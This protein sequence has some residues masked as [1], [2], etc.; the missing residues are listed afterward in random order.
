[1]EKKGIIPW[2]VINT[3]TE[4]YKVDIKDVDRLI[5]MIKQKAGLK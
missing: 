4:Q 3:T 1:M 5:P 2:L